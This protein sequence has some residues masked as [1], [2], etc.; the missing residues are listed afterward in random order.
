M[1]KRGGKRTKKRTHV[2][3]STD[4]QVDEQ[5]PI[6]RSMVI[7]APRCMLPHTLQVLQTEIRKVMS[8]YTAQK[9]KEKK[10]NTLKDYTHVAGLMKVTHFIFLSPGGKKTQNEATNVQGVGV[11]ENVAGAGALLKIARFPQGPT[12]TFRINK[13]SLCRHIRATQKK[14]YDVAAL[15]NTPPL[16][17]LNNFGSEGAPTAPDAAPVPPHIKLMR[18]TFQNMFP[19]IDVV[20]V[21]LTDC[22]YA[23]MYIYIYVC[24]CFFSTMLKLL[25]L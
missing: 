10:N 13:Y 6:P 9:L 3:Q 11:A 8:P 21:R 14:S 5:T 25:F 1:P 12:L 17:V 15:Y 7:R 22:R 4:T 24:V 20:T 18:I 2:L 23:H 16:V 19:A